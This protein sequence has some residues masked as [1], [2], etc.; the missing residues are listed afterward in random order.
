MEKDPHELVD[1]KAVR[2]MIESQTGMHPNALMIGGDA[3][4]ELG[5]E[6]GVYVRRGSKTIY[7]TFEEWEASGG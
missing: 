5:V 7:Y 6:P 3:A 1:V 2:E 4:R